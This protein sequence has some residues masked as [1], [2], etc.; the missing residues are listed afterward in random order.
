MKFPIWLGMCLVQYI[1]IHYIIITILQA[2]TAHNIKQY[3]ETI[4]VH[5]K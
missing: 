3:K 2:Y 5:N 1:L 4:V